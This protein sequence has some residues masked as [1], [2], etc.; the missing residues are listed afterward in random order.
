MMFS[1]QT[2]LPARRVLEAA[3]LAMQRYDNDKHA[4]VEALILHEMRQRSFFG[5]KYRLNR[6]EA[7]TLLQNNKTRLHEAETKED[8]QRAS[9]SGLFLLALA[10]LAHDADAVLLVSSEDFGS[11]AQIYLDEDFRAQ[12]VETNSLD[13]AV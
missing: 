8:P 7:M 4:R 2:A 1:S 12:F 6:S 10:A 9:A 3:K 5:R 13:G 11:I